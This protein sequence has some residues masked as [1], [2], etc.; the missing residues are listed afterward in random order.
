[1]NSYIT[2]D[3][4]WLKPENK[5]ATK[6]SFRIKDQIAFPRQEKAKNSSP[7]TSITFL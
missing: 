2:T 7:Q 1:M 3:H 5:K 4:C 6:L